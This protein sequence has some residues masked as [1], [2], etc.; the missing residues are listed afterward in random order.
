MVEGEKE[1]GRGREREWKREGEMEGG[2][3]GGGGEYNRIKSY[4]TTLGH[5]LESV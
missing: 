5:A 2:R 4:Y 1:S 3:D